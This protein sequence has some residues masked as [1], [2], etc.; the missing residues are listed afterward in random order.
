M[1]GFTRVTR[2]KLFSQSISQYNLGNFHFCTPTADAIIKVEPIPLARSIA[3]LV[4]RSL[5]FIAFCWTVALSLTLVNN[6][7][8]FIAALVDSCLGLHRLHGGQ[9]P[10][11]HRHLGVQ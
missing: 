9:L 10:E 7:M 11:V 3:A 5:T 4:D 1:E 2:G 8:R 6:S